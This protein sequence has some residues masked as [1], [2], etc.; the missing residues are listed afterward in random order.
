MKSLPNLSYQVEMVYSRTQLA[1]PSGFLVLHEKLQI[2]SQFP[3]WSRVA[4]SAGPSVHKGPC[5]YLVMVHWCL[6]E[7]KP[8]GACQAAAAANIG[9]SYAEYSTDRIFYSGAGDQKQIIQ[10]EA[11]ISFYSLWPRRG[12]ALVCQSVVF[13]VTDQT[14]RP[15]TIV[16]VIRNTSMVHQEGNW[17]ELWE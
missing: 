12:V 15:L 1:W 7:L 6:A 14:P 11:L 9:T 10:S 2:T 4:G 3:D 16:P 8:C 17:P 13:Q 5:K